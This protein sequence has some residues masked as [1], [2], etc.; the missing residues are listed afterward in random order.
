MSDAAL[1]LR[2]ER[3]PLTGLSAEAFQHPLDRQAAAHLSKIKG[4]DWLVKKFLEY[5]F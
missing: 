2:N 4:F 1:A 3:V 5:G